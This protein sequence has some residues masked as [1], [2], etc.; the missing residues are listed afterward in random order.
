MEARQVRKH[1]IL[2]E[3]E[4]IAREEPA[5]AALISGHE[6]HEVF[7]AQDSEYSY[8]IYRSR[9]GYSVGR[10]KKPVFI[11]DNAPVSI[12]AAETKEDQF[13]DALHALIIRLDNHA[14]RLE[15]FTESLNALICGL[16]N[17]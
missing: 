9:Y 14:K 3:L 16:V 7:E 6:S 1:R 17:K 13:N 4:T 10:R 8:K 2:W 15:D 5:T 12:A 11:P